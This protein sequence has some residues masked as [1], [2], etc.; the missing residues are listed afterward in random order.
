LAQRVMVLYA[1][2]QME[3]AAA[4]DIFDAPAHPYT[5][6]LL[7]SAPNTRGRRRRLQAIPGSIPQPGADL[8]GCLFALRCPYRA[9]QCEAQ[10]IARLALSREREVTC[11]KPLRDPVP[12]SPM[13]VLP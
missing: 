8:P 1:G 7:A 6:A 13:E 4:A 11:L 9:P 12:V 10:A 3:T 5:Q 2:Q